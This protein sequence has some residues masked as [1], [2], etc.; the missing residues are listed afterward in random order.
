MDLTGSAGV[1]V[2]VD[3]RSGLLAFG[4]ELAVEE[5]SLR[6]LAAAREAYEETPTTA[7]PLYQMANGITRRGRSEPASALRYELTSLRPGVVG[8]EW[9]KTIGHIH[10]AAPDGLGYPEVYEVVAGRAAFVLFKPEPLRCALI[11][12]ERGEQFV[13][14]PDWY[15]LAVNPGAEAM[16]FVDVVARA[17]TPDYTLLRERRGAPLYLGPW[18]VRPNPRY[19]VCETVTVRATELPR[20]VAHG[21]LAD[22]FFGDRGKLDYLLEPGRH[23]P[24]WNELHAALEG[25]RP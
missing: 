6:T 16:V 10:D 4:D 11:E 5:M 22:A 13:I 23:L 24:A 17:V 1:P 25:T 18:G 20:P 15:H 7:P 12:A 3:P 14:P 2:S 9:V 19:G 8:K 21:R